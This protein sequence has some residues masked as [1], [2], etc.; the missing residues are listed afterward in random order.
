[1]L[2]ARQR[3]KNSI[4]MPVCQEKYCL[5]STTEK[6]S[7]WCKAHLSKQPRT[8]EKEK[9]G[10][11]KTASSNVTMEKLDRVFSLKVRTHYSIDGRVACYT[12]GVVKPI[13]QQQNG[14]FIKRDYYHLRWSWENCKVQC[15]TCNMWDDQTEI[16]A[17]YEAKLRAEI[18]DARVDE[19]LASKSE[20]NKKPNELEM[21]DILL[22]FGATDL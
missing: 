11:K 12:C 6:S 16:L 3:A 20:F 9:S 7:R 13:A 5:H 21:Q 4:S 19:M 18:G 22:S 10:M 14:H 17:I 1:M 15:E 8:A 2:Q